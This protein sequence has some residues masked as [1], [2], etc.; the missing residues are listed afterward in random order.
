M[1][2]YHHGNLKEELIACACKLCDRDGYTKLS[3]RSLAKESGVSQ[4]APYR[5]FETK[6]CVYAAV[7]TVG[8]KKLNELV[9]FDSPKKITKTKLVAN[10]SKYIEFGLKNANTYDLMFGTAVGNFA[11]YPDLLKSANETYDNMKDSFASLADDSEQIIAFKCITLWSMLHGLVGIIRKVNVVGDDYD[12]SAGP[13]SS[14]NM[15]A[16]NLEEHL[17]KVISGLISN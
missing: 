7:A 14:A 9:F 15:I 8:F 13:I 2:T 5:H 3:I 11:D 16:N 10:A 6:E 12:D 1:K 4:T 17:D